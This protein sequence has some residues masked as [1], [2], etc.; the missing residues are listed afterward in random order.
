MAYKAVPAKRKARKGVHVMLHLLALLAGILGIY[1]IFKFKH[2]TGSLNMKTLHSWLGI[3]TISLYV[4][5][6]TLLL[7]KICTLVHTIL[8]RNIPYYSVLQ[9]VSS[10]VIFLSI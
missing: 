4:L 2:E 8:V 6:V 7:I 1:V 3:I 5:Q 9:E 10:F